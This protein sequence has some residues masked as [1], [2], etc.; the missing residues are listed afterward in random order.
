MKFGIRL[1]MYLALQLLM[2]NDYVLTFKWCMLDWNQTYDIIS[3][4]I[5]VI[6]CIFMLC[7][8]GLE[9]QKIVL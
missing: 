9:S 2:L 6:C 1:V 8:T 3:I 5:Y 7:K 4:Q